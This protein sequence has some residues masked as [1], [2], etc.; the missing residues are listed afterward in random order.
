MYKKLALFCSLL[1][2]VATGYAQ[3]A[4]KNAK[5]DNNALLWKISGKG[6]K[7]PSYLFGTLHMIC[8]SDYVWTP[9]M[10]KALKQTAKVAFEMDMDDPALQGQMTAGMML[11]AGKTLKD[12]YT[13]AEYDSLSSFA[14]E[15][16]IPLDMMQQFQPF[17][18]ISFMY[19]NV[20]SCT[21]PE[22]YEGNIAKLA[23]DDNKEIV[24]LESVAEQMA[25]IDNMN[26]DSLAHSVLSMATD[27]D[28]FKVLFADMLTLYKKQQLP[29]L[30]ELVI[31]SPDYKDDLNGLL[32]DRNAKW[33][34]RIKELATAQSTFIAVGAGHLWG[35]KGV[36]SLLK[37][38]GYTVVPVK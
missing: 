24:G 35:D 2:G 19:L 26:A 15:H 23:Q 18:L 1:L 37:A 10:Q 16:H 36:I 7:S 11:P 14:K 32:Y 33:I 28:S 12:F 30:Y 21:L 8:Q 38:Q 17:A 34:P 9:A 29:E 25:V 3:I 22:S 31:S 27:L 20:L 13:A 4:K 5:E 6:L